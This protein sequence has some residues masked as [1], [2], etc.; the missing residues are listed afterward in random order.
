[1]FTRQTQILKIYV[2][3]ITFISFYFQYHLNFSHVK[4]IAYF[5]D[6]PALSALNNGFLSIIAVTTGTLVTV[7]CN[8][9]YTLKGYTSLLFQDNGTWVKG[10]QNMYSW[11]V[12]IVTCPIES[13]LFLSYAPQL[14]LSKVKCSWVFVSSPVFSCE[15]SHLRCRLSSADCTDLWFFVV[16]SS[17]N[18]YHSYCDMLLWLHIEKRQIFI[19][20]G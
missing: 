18:R 13:R 20:P 10:G 9:G 16:H 19:L 15:I 4:Y 17:I 8:S 6:C 7:T 1:M 2:V 12:Y 5:A 11:S 14:K 3:W